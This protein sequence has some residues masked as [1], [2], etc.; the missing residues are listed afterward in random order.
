[1]AVLWAHSKREGGVTNFQRGLNSVA[2]CTVCKLPRSSWTVLGNNP[3][4]VKNLKIAFPPSY[5]L[6]SPLQILPSPLLQ[7][8]FRL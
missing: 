5:S 4:D 2:I 3:S 7:E 6:E 1:M 8:A